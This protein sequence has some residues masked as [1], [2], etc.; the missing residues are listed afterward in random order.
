[1]KNNYQIVDKKLFTGDNFKEIIDFCTKW[2]NELCTYFQ[3]TGCMCYDHINT[4]IETTYL[5]R[6]VLLIEPADTMRGNS[7]HV[8]QGQYVV[9]CQRGKYDKFIIVEDKKYDQLSKD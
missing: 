4:E 9:L 2:D 7:V 6:I 3:L 1:M 5:K 8:K